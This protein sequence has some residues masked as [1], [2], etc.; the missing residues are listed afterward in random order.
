M[1]SVLKVGNVGFNNVT[2][3]ALRPALRRVVESRF[4]ELLIPDV[5]GPLQLRQFVTMLRLS[6]KEQLLVGN[7]TQNAALNIVK[8]QLA[9]EIAELERSITELQASR[10]GFLYKYCGLV[11][12]RQQ[13]ELHER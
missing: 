13:L 12:K 11:S 4:M 8:L 9:V 1:G 10:S 6:E 5:S 3:K 7:I 2:S